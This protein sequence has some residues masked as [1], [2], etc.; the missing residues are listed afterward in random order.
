[1]RLKVSAPDSVHGY[2]WSCVWVDIASV[3]KYEPWQVAREGIDTEA[4]NALN[5][6]RQSIHHKLLSLCD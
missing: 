3:V 1:M 6:V 4:S 5:A 2:M